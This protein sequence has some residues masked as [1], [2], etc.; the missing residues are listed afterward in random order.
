MNKLEA[1]KYLDIS[2][3][4]LRRLVEEKILPP[5]PAGGY[6][7]DALRVIYIR[8]LRSVAAGRGAGDGDLAAART[9]LARHQSERMKL[10][11]AILKAEFC[12]VDEVVRVVTAMIAECNEILWSTPA[13]IAHEVDGRAMPELELRAIA[14]KHIGDAIGRLQPDQAIIDAAR[15]TAE[16]IRSNGGKL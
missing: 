4:Q 12:K 7:I 9:E 15:E 2:A 8:H 11:I 3:R 6:D 14:N 1:A 5:M 10:K 13:L 16:W